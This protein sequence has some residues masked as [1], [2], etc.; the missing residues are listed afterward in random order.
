MLNADANLD[1]E[2]RGEFAEAREGKR[3]KAV[4]EGIAGLPPVV[5]SSFWKSLGGWLGEEE[6][7]PRQGCV[8]GF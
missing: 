2:A 8:A 6:R 1:L 3:Q 4:L 7:T 5:E